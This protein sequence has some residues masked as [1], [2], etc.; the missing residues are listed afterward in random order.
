MNTPFD[1]RPVTVGDILERTITLI[2][3]TFTRIGLIFLF[4][5]L[6]AAALFGVV[7]D[8]F[9]SSMLESIAMDVAPDSIAA[10]VIPFLKW[11]VILILAALVLMA[12][13][14]TALVS[15]QIVVCGEIVGRRVETREAAELTLG[16]RLWRA[17]GQ[18]ILADLA[19]AG[20]IVVPYVAII[21]AA[22]S[23]AGAF[24][25][26]ATVL[27]ILVALLGVV[28]L[29]VRWAFGTTVIAWEDETALG[30]FGRSSELVRGS[31]LRTF[32]ILALFAIVVGLLVSMLL[33]PVQLLMFKDI[34]L[35][36]LNQ[37]RNVAL[38]DQHEVLRAL[39]GIGFW[40]GITIALA[41][42]VTTL[43]K[44]VYLPVMYFDLRARGGEFETA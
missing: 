21:V 16:P 27:A 40:Y 39:S 26:L 13:E 44:A 12:V 38:Q 29:K 4:L 43:F 5:A 28:Y 25:I 11:M 31:W 33:S 19:I 30:A 15:M 1:L 9:M 2:R 17:I 24:A 8:G 20:V 34:F 37:A 6:P 7:M 22:A 42:L 35:A 36:G 3:L 23:D 41:N 18:R 32:G 10:F 14:L